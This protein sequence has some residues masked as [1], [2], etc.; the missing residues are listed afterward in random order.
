MSEVSYFS[1]ASRRVPI[2]G[3]GDSAV[4]QISN[5]FTLE[6]I[7]LFYQFRWQALMV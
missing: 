1:P 6:L 5:A 7:D 4:T 3:M 2:E